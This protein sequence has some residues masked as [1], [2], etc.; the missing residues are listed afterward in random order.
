MPEIC[1][2]DARFPPSPT[3][4][5]YLNA[6]G[7]LGPAAALLRIIRW[8]L[9]RATQ[10]REGDDALRW[11]TTAQAGGSRLLGHRLGCHSGL[12]RSVLLYDV[13]LGAF[14]VPRTLP[15]DSFH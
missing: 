11:K 2:D 14:G 3:D 15:R 5:K 13:L 9:E 4:S 1:E 12:D 10:V 8:V 6:G 7:F